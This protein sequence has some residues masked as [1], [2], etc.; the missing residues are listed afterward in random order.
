MGN[1]KIAN[2]KAPLSPELI[3]VTWQTLA[4]ESEARILA[5]ELHLPLG[6]KGYPYALEVTKE[7]LALVL[8]KTSKTSRLY[9][10]FTQGPLGYRLARGGKKNQAIAKAIGL[11]LLKKKLTVLDVTAGLGGDALVL[12]SLGCTVQLV[13]RSR[14]I[15]ALLRDGLRR[16][17]RNLALQST[18]KA[19]QLTVADSKEILQHISQGD[20]PDIVYLDPMFPQR[21][22]SALSKIEMRMLRDI[23]GNDEDADQ[24]FLLAFNKARKRVVVKRPKQAPVLSSFPPT[25]VV[26]GK[27]SRYD[28]YLTPTKHT[29]P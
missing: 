12:A 5:Q 9:V 19:I 27:S 24:L 17:E 6:A 14:I 21:S 26:T 29:I 16:A 7:H 18:V 11:N 22:K 2:K 1:K 15:A 23:V 8:Q 3:T 25:F 28:V 13:E 20:A 10:D 4:C